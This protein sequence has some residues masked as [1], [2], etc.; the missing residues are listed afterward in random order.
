MATLLLAALV[1]AQAS[2]QAPRTAKTNQ[3]RRIEEAITREANY[4]LSLQQPNGRFIKA[5]DGT[6]DPG[7]RNYGGKDAVAMLGLAYAGRSLKDDRIARGF[8]ALLSLKLD[9][10]YPV[11]LRVMVIT[12]YLDS[13]DEARKKRSQYILEQ[14][15][16]WLAGAQNAMGAWG[17][18]F[19]DGRRGR[20]W[21]FCNSATAIRALGEACAAGIRIKKTP[22]QKLQAFYIERQNSDGGWDYGRGSGYGQAPN[23]SYGT[24]SAAATAAM[25]EM[26]WLFEPS[27]GCPCSSSKPK[28]SAKAV[29]QAIERGLRWIGRNFEAARNPHSRNG[30]WRRYWL[31]CVARAGRASGYKY[32]GTHDWYREGASSIINSNRDGARTS[33][34]AMSEAAYGIGFLSMCREP[35]LVSKLKFPGKWNSHPTDMAHLTEYMAGKIGQALRWQVLEPGAKDSELQEAPLLFVGVEDELRLTNDEKGK[36]RRFTDNGGTIFLEAVCGSRKAALSIERLCREVWPEWKLDMLSRR[37]DLWRCGPEL[38]GRLPRI[39][40]ID[41]GVRT[42]VFYAP[43]GI[44][45]AF[46]P[47][48]AKK[49]H[50]PLEAMR[51][52]AV[53]ATDREPLLPRYEVKVDLFPEKYGKR[54]IKA[55]SKKAITLARINYGE[56]SRSGSNYGPWAKLSADLQKRAGLTVAE[57]E[58]V[59]VGQPV[60]EGVDFLY[61]TG[62]A[63]CSL[64]EGGA[65][66]LKK[67]LDG[68]GF[69]LAEATCG[70]PRFDKSLKAL[71]AE[72]G[73]TYRLMGAGSPLMTGQLFD[74]TGYDASKVGYTRSLAAARTGKSD[75]VIH[76]IYSGKKLVGLYSPYDILFSQT[77]CR[78]FGNLGYAK[79]DAR[80]LAT[81]I[82][83]LMSIK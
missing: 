46:L 54:K 59:P 2:A 43:R 13:L 1:A 80:A 79:A 3:A 42:A 68:G 53:Y 75:A 14:D 45:C 16:T 4:L 23:R 47:Q 5:D 73:L 51:N 18:R 48:M 39:D 62:R 19:Q 60:P 9:A 50:L 8:D 78:A 33:D 29:N 26:R 24:M 81:N 41:D 10:T 7:N 12:H 65:A 64:G 38:V 82:A 11:A 67:Y 58:A 70:D 32:F 77:G 56:R 37:H 44:S 63:D 61:L 31:Y 28:R 34:M 35:L 27:I 55:G 49:N 71:L 40:G 76:G 22:F 36:L 21:D 30:T 15:L 52:L 25:L 66:W 83:L 72:A 17:Y 57:I 20:L 74:A 69:L 6:A